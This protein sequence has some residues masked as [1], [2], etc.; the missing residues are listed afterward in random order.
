MPTRIAITG[1]KGGTGKS[2]IATAFALELS[3]K[4][5]VLLVDA[6]VDCPND[7]LI[8]EIKRKKIKDIFQ[9]IPKINKKKCKKC[10]NC[11]R[12]CRENAIVQI[13]GEYPILISDQ[14]IGCSACEIACPHGAIEKDKKK[15]GTIYQGEYK[16]KNYNLDFYSAETEIGIEEESPIVNALKS[17]IEKIEKN[18]DFIVFDTSPGTHCNVI[19]ALQGCKIAYSVTEPTPLGEHDGE[20]SLRLLNKLKIPFKVILNKSDIGNKELIK[21]LAK[22][23]NTEIIVEVPYK[24]SILQKYSQGKPIES[25]GIKKLVEKLNKKDYK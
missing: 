11:S 7:H 1:G 12:V 14:C 21:K 13:K 15:I 24:K 8:L 3:K 5:R 22:N 17:K 2:T 23:Y 6:D 19:S 25:E 16:N 4:N 9:P 18:Y 10:G 20:L